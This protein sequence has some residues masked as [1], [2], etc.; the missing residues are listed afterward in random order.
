MEVDKKVFK[1]MFPNLAKEMD[2]R[3]QGV[4]ISSVRLDIT[5]AERASSDKFAGYIPDVVDYIR[6]CDTKEQAEEIISYLEKRGEVSSD[7]ARR[8]RRQL[9][10]KGVRSFG[11]KKEDGYYLKHGIV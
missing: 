9:R 3:R 4:R 8:L 11:P 10:E 6:R 5:A 7:Y 2:E 1:R